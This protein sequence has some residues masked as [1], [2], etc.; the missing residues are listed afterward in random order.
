MISNTLVDFFSAVRNYI[1]NSSLFINDINIAISGNLDVGALLRRE[2]H[3]FAA[4]SLN[5]NETF[6]DEAERILSSVE[7]FNNENQELV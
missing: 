3:Q 7:R 5:T 6:Y 2:I 4:E 1:E